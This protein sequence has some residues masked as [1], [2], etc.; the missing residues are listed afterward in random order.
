ML[1]LA[2][3][4]TKSKRPRYSNPMIDQKKNNSKPTQAPDVEA[5]AGCCEGQ[6]RERAGASASDGARSAG[7]LGV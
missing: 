4:R 2:A 5:G 7:Y 6:G 1:K 3:T